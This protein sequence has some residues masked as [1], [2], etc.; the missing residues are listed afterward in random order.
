M[1][2]RNNHPQKF[3]TRLEQTVY[4]KKYM[5][6]NRLVIVS[7]LQQQQSDSFHIRITFIFPR[8]LVL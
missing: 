3:I 7:I 8:N 6:H 1:F 5:L 2:P 4:N